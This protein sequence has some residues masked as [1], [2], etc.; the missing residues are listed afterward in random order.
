MVAAAFAVIPGFRCSDDATHVPILIREVAAASAA[1][2]AMPS[3]KPNLG[4]STTRRPI[5]SSGLQ[6]VAKP[7]DSA[8]R[9]RSRISVHRTVDPSVVDRHEPRT[10][11]ISNARIGTS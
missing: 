1:G 7:S 2:I 10:R 4:P 9:A 11:P 6:T 3:Q 5:S 8:R